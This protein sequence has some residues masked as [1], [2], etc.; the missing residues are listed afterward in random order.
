MRRRREV[1]GDVCA[2][3]LLQFSPHLQPPYTCGADSTWQLKKK[4]G[5]RKTLRENFSKKIFLSCPI[6]SSLSYFFFSPLTFFVPVRQSCSQVHLF[7][8]CHDLCP[9]FFLPVKL[10]CSPAALFHRFLFCSSLLYFSPLIRTFFRFYSYFFVDFL[11]PHHKQRF[12]SVVSAFTSWLIGAFDLLSV[13]VFS[14]TV[15][16]FYSESRTLLPV[17]KSYVNIYFFAL[18]G[19]RTFFALYGSRTFL[20]SMEVVLFCSAWNRSS[21]FFA[22]YGSRTFLLSMDVVLFCSLWKSYFFSP[23]GSLTFFFLCMEVVLFCSLWK[24]YFFFSV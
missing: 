12:L 23:Y 17:W 3:R 24:S 21:T 20:L 22:L 8:L 5:K 13:V 9:K 10:Y 1:I 2:R 4:W 16:L 6:I 7:A 19:S 14:L 15:V 11:A 18:H